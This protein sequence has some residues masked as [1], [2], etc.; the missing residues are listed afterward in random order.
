MPEEL[1][2]TGSGDHRPENIRRDGQIDIIRPLVN[3]DLPMTARAGVVRRSIS[4]RLGDFISVKD[5]GAKGDG[6]T[7]D[8]LAIVA[9]LEA[10]RVIDSPSRTLYFPP[11]V[12]MLN[13]VRR[14]VADQVA[15]PAGGVADPRQVVVFLDDFSN[16]SRRGTRIFGHGAT[17]KCG[18]QLPSPIVALNQLNSTTPYS[19]SQV[20]TM[21]L[22]TN[23][24]GDLLIEGLKID[25]DNRAGYGLQIQDQNG[26]TQKGSGIQGRGRITIR[27]CQ[28]VN[29]Y[30]RRIPY[31]ND[32][33]DL[34]LNTTTGSES[35][36]VQ[37]NDSSKHP[38][39]GSVGLNIYTSSSNVLVDGCVIKNIGRDPFAGVWSITG[40]HGMIIFAAAVGGTETSSA[41]NQSLYYVSVKDGNDSNNGTIGSPFKTLAKAAEKARQDTSGKDI[42]I[43]IRGGEYKMLGTVV[44]P[45]FYLNNLD[46]GRNGKK[47][48]YRAYGNEE[49]VITGSEKISPS[50]FRPLSETIDATVWSRI[51]S[52]V[53]PNIMVADLS[54][55]D[56]GLPLPSVW[57]G[58]S[59]GSENEYVSDLPTIPELFFNDKR[60]TV[61]RWPNI[62]TSE[63]NGYAFEDSA[64]IESVIN[65]GTSGV[66]DAVVWEANSSSTPA[67]APFVDGIFEYPAS[68][69]SVV[70]RWT[71][72]V[73]SGV[74]MHGFW[75]WDWADEV[76]KVVNINTT[77]R[78]ITVRSRKS[79][80][81]LQNYTLCSPTGVS[82]PSGSFMS[83]PTK[84][85]WYAFNLPEE[86]D[87]PGEYFIDINDK[88]LY[89]YP[90]QNIHANSSIRLSHRAAGGPTQNGVDTTGD[91]I[92]DNITESGTTGA[93]P[94]FPY[95]GWAPGTSASASA[96]TTQRK[97]FYNTRD[98][99][100]SLFKFHKVK[101]VNVEGLTFRDCSGSGI[102]LNM[103][104]NMTINKCKVFNMRRDGIAAMG[105]KNVTIQKCE[106]YDI[107]R[108]AVINTGGN[109]Q[110]LTA[111]NKL[112][113]E[114]SVK[115]W[116]R[117]KPT[118]S[119]GLIMHGVGNT[120][121]KNLF[122]DGNTAIL[123]GGNDHVIELNH[124]HNLLADVDDQGAIY[125]GRDMSSINKTVRKNFFNNVGSRLPGGPYGSGCTSTG[126]HLTTA[127]YWDDHESKHTISENVFYRCGNDVGAVFF[128][129]G[130]L[131]DVK[132][133][134]FVE[135]HTAYGA[136]RYSQASWNSF[137]GGRGDY[138]FN[139]QGYP[140]FEDGL[141][142]SPPRIIGYSPYNWVGS[143]NGTQFYVDANW[144]G[145]MNTVNIRTAIYQQKYTHLATFIEDGGSNT[146]RLVS[147]Q[148]NS[149][150]NTATR[151][152][153][154]NC[155]RSINDVP[156]TTV[157]GWTVTNEMI[158]S[159]LGIFVNPNSQ[160]FKLTPAGLAA[161]KSTVGDSFTDIPFEQIPKVDYVPEKYS[162]LVDYQSQ[163]TVTVRN[164][165]IENVYNQDGW[166]N[167][168]P[169]TPEQAS[170]GGVSSETIG[171]P[172]PSV[173][174]IPS[175]TSGS[176]ASANV[177]ADGMLVYA[178]DRRITSGL[179]EYDNCSASIVGNHFVN[180]KGR[181]VKAQM[182]EVVIQANISHTAIKP[183][184]G[185]FAR[186]NCQIG[187][188]QVCDNI[189]HIETAKLTSG[190]V[191]G[192]GNPFFDAP[193]ER[194]WAN[195]AIYE[196]TDLFN[197]DR[198]RSGGG[199]VSFYAGRRLPR[200]RGITITGNHVYNNVP[201]ENGYLGNLFSTT[202]G[203][204]TSTTA[205]NPAPTFPNEP[206]PVLCSVSQNK[207]VGRAGSQS[208][209]FGYLGTRGDGVQSSTNPV[210][211]VYY[212]INDNMM[213][214]LQSGPETS[215]GFPTSTFLAFVDGS[216]SRNFVKCDGNVHAR[217]GPQHPRVGARRPNATTFD[218][219]YDGN[220]SA[221]DNR[222]ISSPYYSRSTSK[223][224]FGPRI[225]TLASS[226]GE[227][228]GIRVKGFSKNSDPTGDA[229]YG[230]IL[231]KG[232][233]EDPLSCIVIMST[234]DWWEAAGGV[235]FVSGTPMPDGTCLH[236]IN[237]AGATTVGSRLVFS[238]TIFSGTS[239][240]S[241]VD[242]RVV[243]WLSQEQDA[244]ALSAGA[245]TSY[246]QNNPAFYLNFINRLDSGSPTT[247]R[248]FTFSVF[249]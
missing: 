222:N 66:W 171:N 69:D 74:W 21:I 217:I 109:R 56:L 107:G 245:S 15:N 242:G 117:L 143:D 203:S 62:A 235:F 249:G 168:E 93:T 125:A 151:N 223:R 54:A 68:Y 138:I 90:P 243:L 77:T 120:A 52:D 200:N 176:W 126:T 41:S 18:F 213:N 191:E 227:S 147:S 83:N 80:Y 43:L 216:V 44:N 144:A 38:V 167:Y 130:V 70:S 34:T 211:P 153:I 137:L 241:A 128:N 33:T 121:S 53:R 65:R 161:V 207:I 210:T 240:P 64:Y 47:I 230:R 201:F 246:L 220:L 12:Y 30:T 182:E 31:T 155:T 95:P 71:S 131:H 9:A 108:N 113:T 164:C 183:I 158:T 190:Q 149:M 24:G 88:K 179:E 238:K 58:R 199:V 187:C 136:S 72:A 146:P 104:E 198:I 195:S 215:P 174:W 89:F 2:G 22:L 11:G 57:N 63:R 106:V 244:D 35:P 4:Q 229:N 115:R 87:A 85:R 189:F 205:L 45:V 132:N 84:R 79:Q 154:V 37:S 197:G 36:K 59:N 228:D 46:S 247:N 166:G 28:F 97:H 135:C 14:T 29:M 188:G 193:G 39:G 234:K 204:L 231:L 94:Q 123:C 122:S 98:I 102:E 180:C 26:G 105:G 221:T 169:L 82:N 224:S 48:V 145:V 239:R 119:A 157:G 225:E 156:G 162:N 209:M 7:D 1:M 49:V 141:G 194:S 192:D 163:K 237:N 140:W 248:R 142:T 173:V 91:G 75:R 172:G 3:A 110:T 134:I 212:I 226:D 42:H 127:V 103:C 233:D 165:H 86:L 177:D 152:I 78:Q 25:G 186:M 148:I 81:A 116:G 124:F 19:M 133:N 184:G 20:S 40:C 8:R 32:G 96:E 170:A 13:S 16:P 73:A 10:L 60:M 118:H 160:N 114:C 196:Q 175:G 206:K 218:F 5:F 92:E 51:K 181:D 208:Q 50:D 99:L 55:F 112:V 111:A 202:E 17:I 159:D 232:M 61:A 100:K 185:G 150:K 76:Y 129:G 139:N 6:V 67:S 214:N 27:S 178:G 101:D 23:G 236:P 219:T